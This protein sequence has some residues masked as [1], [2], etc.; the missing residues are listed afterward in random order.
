MAKLLRVLSDRRG[1]NTYPAFAA[2]YEKAARELASKTGES[3]LRT[4][5]VSESTFERWYG[6]KVQ[7]Q[8]QARRVLAQMFGVPF[9]DLLAEAQEDSGPPAAARLASAMPFTDSR[10]VE[11]DAD[12]ERLGRL[13][14]MA[15]RRAL[16]FALGAEHNEVG[17]E[18]LGYLHE[19]VRR[20]AAVYVRVPLSEIMD[21]L[22]QVQDRTFRIIESGRAKPAQLRDL[23]LLAALESGMLAKAAHDLGDPRSAMAQARTAAICAQPA[24]HRGMSLWVQ[25]L[26]SLISYWADRP[27]DALH[28][29][30]MGSA[31][32]G[33]ARGSVTVWLAGLEA[34]AA[35][36]LGDGRAVLRANRRASQLRESVTPDDLDEIGGLF[37]FPGIRQSYYEVE[38]RVLLGEVDRPL[39]DR[40]LETVEGHQ[41]TDT[42]YWAFGDAAGARSHL[43]LARLHTG[44]LDGAAEAVHPV[45]DLAPNQRNAG[46]VG[47]VQ[48]VRTSLMRRPLSDAALARELREEIAVFGS[49]A[50]LALPR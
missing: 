27:E 44:D 46:I 13:A 50:A 17:P 12:N 40:A 38:A 43:A 20:I 37:L 7:P 14:V 3:A 39:L 49:Q 10:R 19:E 28:Y 35:G 21:D 24:D 15:A 47:S 36:S 4:L 29:A 33:D 31:A 16:D 2:A 26:K 32:T 25:G 5:A 22:A 6:G 48:R 34:R 18:T 23:Y 8:Q 42:P 41:D 9:A 1:W 30:R 11:P 45:L